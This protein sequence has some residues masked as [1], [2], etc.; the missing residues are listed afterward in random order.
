[1]AEKA[2]IDA[3]KRGLKDKAAEAEYNAAY[4][5]HM[6]KA[7]S[8]FDGPTLD[9]EKSKRKSGKVMDVRLEEEARDRRI[10]REHHEVSRHEKERVRKKDHRDLDT[11][12]RR[13]RESSRER[14]Q[15]HK[16]DNPREVETRGHERLSK[17]QDGDK[18]GKPDNERGNRDVSDI[19]GGASTHKS[20]TDV[21][22]KED[23]CNE[24][25]KLSSIPLDEAKRN[26]VSGQTNDGADKNGGSVRGNEKVDNSLTKEAEKAPKGRNEENTERKE[27]SRSRSRSAEN[28]KGDSQ[29]NWEQEMEDKLSKERERSTRREDK[30]SKRDRS[31]RRD[32]DADGQHSRESERNKERKRSRDRG[33]IHRGRDYDRDRDRR[34][35]D[36]D[37]DHRKERKDYRSRSRDRKEKDRRSRSRDRNEKER[38]K[39]RDHRH[40]SRS[41]DRGEPF[42]EK[43]PKND[44][45]K[46]TQHF[47]DDRFSDDGPRDQRHIRGDFVRDERGPGSGR[48]RF[49]GGNSR[50]GF[51]QGNGG[52]PR[53]DPMM[54]HPPGREGDFPGNMHHRRGGG[55]PRWDRHPD[56][57][58]RERDIQWDRE[59]NRP[60]EWDREGERRDRR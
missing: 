20:S 60:R 32:R 2:K 46:E 19:D 50:G 25:L 47:H 52:P 54:N 8:R 40:R 24:D 15:R 33:R 12:H 57:R 16:A 17:R 5:S 11:K 26:E 3:K 28:S 51:H 56:G 13:S 1:V 53:N 18:N 36:R 4:Q 43:L 59:R 7:A 41:R 38:K 39:D 6:K 14:R 48:G 49:S 22:N 34:R 27:R 31:P 45:E 29:K 21:F 9:D 44:M 35:R 37:R 42:Y 30:E 10:S 55:P 58:D 23:T